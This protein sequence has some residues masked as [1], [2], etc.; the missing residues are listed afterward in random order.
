MQPRMKTK[1]QDEVLP[2]VAEQFGVDSTPTFFI[3]GVKEA[4][5]LTLEQLEERIEPLL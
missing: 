2:K 5:A 1:F 3:N 4:G